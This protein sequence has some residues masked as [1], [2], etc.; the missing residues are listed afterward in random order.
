MLFFPVQRSNISALTREYC[1][2]MRYANR[3]VLIFS[4]H[5]FWNIQLVPYSSR[6]TQCSL[7]SHHTSYLAA[8]ESL[9]ACFGTTSNASSFD[10]PRRA[11]K[12]NNPV[13]RTAI[14]AE[15][16]SIRKL[17]KTWRCATS[18]REIHVDVDCVFQ[19]AETDCRSIAPIIFR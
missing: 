17:S 4:F 5:W 9:H 8:M 14:G 12:R 18:Q 13:M 19:V 16:R 1:S 6:S 3:D 7:A 11:G 10:L 15:M 2:F